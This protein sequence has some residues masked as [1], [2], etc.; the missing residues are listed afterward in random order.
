MSEKN[1]SKKWAEACA[2]SKGTMVMLPEE[3]KEKADE[4]FKLI[5]EINKAAAAVNKDNIKLGNVSNNLW[6]K[7]RQLL[8]EPCGDKVYK[9]DMD[10]NQEAKEDGFYVINFT[11]PRP[12][13]PGM[14]M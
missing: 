2:K 13:G 8:E 5:E 4:M 12:Q 14:R 1:K 3:M 10:F 9:M 6:F 7:I 11:Q